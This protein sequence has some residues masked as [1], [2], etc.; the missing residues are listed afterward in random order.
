MHLWGRLS[1]RPPFQT[2]Y[3]ATNWFSLL[4]GASKI[5][6]WHGWK[7][8][9]Y[10]PSPGWS[11]LILRIVHCPQRYFRFFPSLICMPCIR[12]ISAQLSTK[13]VESRQC[14]VL[15]SNGY[16]VGFWFQ[17]PGFNSPQDLRELFLKPSIFFSSYVLF[18]IV[19]SL[20]LDLT[21]TI[22]EL[23]SKLWSK[24]CYHYFWVVWLRASGNLLG[25]CS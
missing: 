18:C 16:D 14:L 4:L 7:G 20:Q 22:C 5:V 25:G 23:G 8:E 24:L 15:W 3:W 11:Y 10:E 12:W 21:L 17:R 9:V 6:M 1:T 19:F 2:K 13:S